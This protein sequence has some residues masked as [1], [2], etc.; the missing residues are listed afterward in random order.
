V[1]RTLLIVAAALMF[2]NTVVLPTVAKADGVGSTSC[3]S[4][5]KP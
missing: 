3:P 2:L 1:K 5:C 4:G